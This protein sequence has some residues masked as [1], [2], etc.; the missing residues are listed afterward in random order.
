[1]LTFKTLQLKKESVVN[2]FQHS[3]K[4]EKLKK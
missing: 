2:I 4:T 3:V 1:M